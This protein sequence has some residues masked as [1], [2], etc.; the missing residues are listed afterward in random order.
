MKFKLNFLDYCDS[1]NIV[2]ATI[3]R[4]FMNFKT[5]CIDAQKREWKQV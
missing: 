2:E 4:D 3:Q 5:I 1:R